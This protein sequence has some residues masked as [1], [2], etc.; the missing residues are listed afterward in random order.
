M[1]I[2]IITFHWATNYGAVLQAYAL[3][4]Y[5]TNIGAEARIINYYPKRYKKNIINAFKT[6]HISSIP[7]RIKEISKE[8]QIASFRERQ[9]NMTQYYSTNR[10]LLNSDFKFDCYMCGSDQIWNESFLMGG[11]RK[12]TYSYFLNFAPDDKTI[13]SYAA[14]FGT[15]QYNE[16]L[17]TDLKKYLSRFDFISVRENSGINILHDVGIDNACVVPDPTMLL[18]KEAYEKFVIGNSRNY[19]YNFVYM[20][21]GKLNDISDIIDYL[22]QKGESTEISANEGIE[23]WLSNIYYAEHIITNSFHGIVFSIIFQ[24]PFTAVLIDGSG[25]NDRIITLLDKFELSDR[26]Y[27]NNKEISEKAIDWKQTE[28]KL[29]EYRDVGIKYISEILKY[30]KK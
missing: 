25:M 17:K 11:E 6:R 15:M 30:H 19:K 27:R 16:H 13:A 1:K 28:Y 23:E 24:R 4:K 18:T 7:G 9:L 8:K 12:K 14:S 5:L 20:L 3:S 29:K 21:H 22:H 10:Q 26:I 2:G